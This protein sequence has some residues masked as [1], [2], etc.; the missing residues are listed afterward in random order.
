MLSK[1]AVSCLTSRPDGV[2]SAAAVPSAMA[3]AVESVALSAPLQLVRRSDCARRAQRGKVVGKAIFGPN[4]RTISKTTPT[5]DLRLAL[6][7]GAHL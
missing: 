4:S 5:A 6:T 7:P 2:G 3:S 1:A